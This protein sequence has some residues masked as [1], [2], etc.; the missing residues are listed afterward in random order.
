MLGLAVPALLAGL[1]NGICVRHTYASDN[2]DF[3]VLLAMDSDWSGAS[4]LLYVYA[5]F[6]VPTLFALLVGLNILAWSRSRINY[7]FIFGA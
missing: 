3:S 7:S 6:F 2:I 1:F 4:G 5:M